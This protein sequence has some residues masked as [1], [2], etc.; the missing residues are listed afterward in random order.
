VEKLAEDVAKTVGAEASLLLA[1]DPGLSALTE[2]VAGILG[3]G[4]HR[5]TVFNDIRSDPLGRQVDAGAEMAR[6]TGAKAV[7]C[8][9]GGS[10]LDAGKLIAAIAGADQ[11]AEFYGLAANRF[12]KAQLKKICIPT[13]AGTGSEAT[14]IAVITNSRDEKVWCFG[15][16]LKADLSVLDPRLLVGL[17]KHLTAA[18]GAD[19]L[20]HAI[21]AMTNRIANPM[22]DAVCLQAIRLISQNLPRAVAQPDDLNARGAVQIAACLAGIGID[23]AGTAV[24]HAI[25]HALGAIGHVHHGRA[26]ALS[27]RAA[28]GWNAEASPERHAMVAGALGIPCEGRK[29]EAV[30]R[31]LA[32]AFDAFLREIG[33]NIS[34]AGDGL[35]AA[36]SERLAATTMAPE[37]AVM[38]D[39][40][41][42]AVSPAD[43]WQFAQAIL[44]AA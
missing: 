18:T 7:V 43:A 5:V 42:R 44:T 17:P 36:D 3:T 4:G 14:T 16:E 2:R 41:I 24:A 30:V 12:P 35:G 39:A 9:G 1:A 27:L 19:A 28:I 20:V 40:N 21:E 38:R 22:N 11:P 13:T 29:T 34:L 23:N 6:K 10:T 15:R 8:L 37:N 31:D 25:G 33:L 32:P 26:V